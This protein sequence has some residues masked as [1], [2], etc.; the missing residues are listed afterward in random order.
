[1]NLHSYAY[2]HEMAVRV[3]RKL[4]RFSG[5][6]I[7]MHRVD[8]ELLTEQ[9]NLAGSKRLMFLDEPVTEDGEQGGDRRAGPLGGN[10]ALAAT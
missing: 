2:L 4:R 3:Y 6:V 10:V 8:R 9:R 7:Y 1:M 5:R